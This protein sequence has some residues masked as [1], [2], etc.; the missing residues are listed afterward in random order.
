MSSNRPPF[1]EGAESSEPSSSFDSFKKP[2]LPAAAAS[3]KLSQ[4]AVAF[5]KAKKQAQ[6][7]EEGYLIEVYRRRCFQEIK[8]ALGDEYSDEDAEIVFQQ[9]LEEKKLT[10]HLKK[11]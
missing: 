8:E 5:H 1:S 9:F 11:F 3:V 10:V 7:R 2:E 4:S 6:S